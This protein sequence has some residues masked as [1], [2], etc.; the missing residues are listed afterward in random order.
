MKALYSIS[1]VLIVV[2]VAGA[3]NP[4]TVLDIYE[5]AHVTLIEMPRAVNKLE[6]RVEAAERGDREAQYDIALYHIAT[7]KWHFPA[8]YRDVLGQKDPEH[9]MAMMREAANAG[10]PDAM[11]ILSR[12][13]D[14]DSLFVAALEAGSSRAIGTAWMRLVEN[15]CDEEASAYMDIVLE[16][17]SDT[18]YPWISQRANQESQDVFSKWWAELLEGLD[19]LDAIRTETCTTA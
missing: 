11:Y 9:G 5:T 3:F 1:A 4:D 14:D 8:Y 19:K 7:P 6:S 10:H 2:L 12:R 15:P 13:Q 18:G 16:H 17:A